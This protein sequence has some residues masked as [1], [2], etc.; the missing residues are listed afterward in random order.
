MKY[1]VYLTTNIKNQHIYIGVHKTKNPD[2]FDGYIG[3]G[4]NRFSPKSMYNSKS[5]FCLAVQKYGFDSFRRSIIKSF[6]TRQ[7]ALDLEAELVDETFIKRSDTY[8]ITLGGGMPPL[9]NKKIYEYNTEDGTL[10][11]EWTSIVE[12]ATYYKCSESCIGQAVSLKRMSQN[13]FWSDCK[14]NRLDTSAYTIY[15]PKIPIYIYNNDGTFYKRCKSMSEC[16]TF[17]KDN[18]RHIQRAVKIGTSV[19]GYYLSLKLTSMFEKPKFEVLTGL[20]H[21]Y[22]LN[23]EYIQ[24]FNSIKEAEQK[25]NCKLQGINTSIKMEQQYKGFLWRRG[26]QK[27]ENIPPYKPSK[28]SAKKIGQYTM[29]DKLVQIFNTVREARKQFPNVSKVL[30]GIA[31]HCHNFKF[32]YIE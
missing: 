12:A 2:I 13:R 14:F 3:N 15:S 30:K 28:S 1:I 20:V 29:D 6:D 9:L 7:E 19:K 24:S 18:L 17:L 8:N 31:S 23:G 22:N 25:L 27:L 16:V 21:Q 10:I 32:K 26:D 4:I 11:K 5:P